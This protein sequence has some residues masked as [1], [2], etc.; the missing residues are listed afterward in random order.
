MERAVLEVIKE[1]EGAVE[2]YKAGKKEALNFLVGQVMKKTR[3]RAEPKEVTEMLKG[4]VE[5]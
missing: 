3:G 4:K 5:S 2:D 1:N